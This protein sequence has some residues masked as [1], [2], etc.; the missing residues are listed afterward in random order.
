MATTETDRQA[1][2]AV[3]RLGVSA[4]TDKSLKREIVRGVVAQIKAGI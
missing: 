2:E 3:E 4:I 1:L